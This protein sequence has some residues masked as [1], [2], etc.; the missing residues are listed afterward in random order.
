M[1]CWLPHVDYE[2]HGAPTRRIGAPDPR[3]AARIQAALGDARTVLNVGAGAGLLRAGGPLGARGRAE[4][5][6]ARPAPAGRGPGARR[7]RPRRCRSTTTRSTRRWRASRSTTGSRRRPASRELRRVARGPVVVFTFDLDALPAWQQRLPRARGSRSSGPRFPRHRRRSPQ[8]SAARRGSS[9]IP[10]PADCTRRLLRG[11]LEPAR[12]AARPGRPRVAVDVGA[13]RPGR[14]GADRRPAAAAL[15]RRWDAEHGHLREQDEFDGSL[16]LVISEPGPDAMDLT[17]APVPPLGP[18]TTSAAR[19]DAPL[20]VIYADFAC[21]HC[22]RR[23]RAPARRR[24]CA[25]RS[26]T[27]R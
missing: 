6:D 4:R 23:P 11:V 9:A 27:S 20:V 24:R 26:A 22:A 18:T 25:S 14:R 13:A 15:G 17:S 2:E 1:T 16:R 12:G 7:A 8:R 5:D 10:T 21:P 3:I 19:D